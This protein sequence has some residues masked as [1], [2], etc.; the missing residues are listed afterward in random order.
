MDKTTDGRDDPPCCIVFGAAVRSGG[1]PS[2][3]LRRRVDGAFLIGGVAARYFVTGGLGVHPPAEAEVMARLLRAHGVPHGHIVVDVDATDT[4]ASARNCAR[5][6]RAHGRCSRVVV[7]SS[8]YHLPRCRMLL[9]RLGVAAVSGSMPGDRPG[10]SRAKLAY[11][12]FRELFAY[13][14]DLVSVSLPRWRL[15]R[16]P[17]KNGDEPNGSS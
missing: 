16:H 4:L 17:G 14:W 1:E 3:T 9:R 10:L 13:P 8:R 15:S 12:Y 2:G 11:F 5:L 7:C 6:I